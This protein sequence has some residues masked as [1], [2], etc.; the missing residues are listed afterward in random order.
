MEERMEQDHRLADIPYQLRK[1]IAPGNAA[2]VGEILA[3]ATDADQSVLPFGGANSV[4]TGNP[5]PGFDLGLDLTEIRGVVSWEPADLVLS[6]HAGT[7]FAEVQDELSRHNQAIPV[8]VTYP[9][10][11]TIGGLIATGFAGPRRLR[12]GS[13]R[14]LM[15]GCEYVRGDGLVANAGG[16]VVKNVSGFEVPR[17]LHGSWGALAVLTTVNLKVTPT[18]RS[19]GT[20][21]ASLTTVDQAI[22]RGHDLIAR[23]P[24]LDACTIVVDRGVVTIATRSLGRDRAVSETMAEVAS[25]S[26]PGEMLSGVE[27]AQW[28]QRHLDRFGENQQG[29][30]LAVS[31]R[32]RIT[33]ELVRRMLDVP[34]TT[35]SASFSIDP[36]LGSVRVLVDDDTT[37]LLP[38]LLDVVSVSQSSYVLEKVSS[39]DAGEYDPWGPEPDGMG[40]MRALKREF[41]PADVLNRGR[42]MVS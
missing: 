34:G 7:T 20:C 32:P 42:L 9:D 39:G 25:L 11:A 33:A 2:E 17:F 30:L 1:V 38:A 3:G 6:V 8:D 35:E 27:S 26:G 14:D 4:V 41:D 21:L 5:V 40:I 12:S 28:W 22:S 16:M 10:R 29:S 24:T 19:D 23:I 36:G 31:T 13:F 18:P 37:P 15:I